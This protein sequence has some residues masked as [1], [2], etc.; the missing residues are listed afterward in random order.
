MADED[1]GGY[2]VYLTAAIVIGGIIAFF[3]LL[4]VTMKA[5][6]IPLFP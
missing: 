1:A 3:I 4:L 6:N 2:P 5:I